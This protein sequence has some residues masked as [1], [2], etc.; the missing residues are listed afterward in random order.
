[1]KNSKNFL[2]IVMLCW[3]LVGLAQNPLIKAC[4]TGDLEAAKQA[5]ADGAD[6][7][8]LDA[9]GR[10]VLV[11]AMFWPEITQFLIEKGADPN[12]GTYPALMQAAN[13]YSYET[14][15]VLLENGA[16]VNKPQVRTR[17]HPIAMMINAERAKKKPNKKLLKTWEEQLDQQ[18]GSLEPIE[19]KL[20]T[21]ENTINQ[22]NCR[23]CLEML[24]KNGA[25]PNQKDAVG[26]DMLSNAALRH[27]P[28]GENFI[29]YGK[30][31]E[32]D[33][34]YRVPDW[35]EERVMGGNSTEEIKLLL[36]AGADLNYQ[37]PSNGNTPLLAA[38]G[39]QNSEGAKLLISKGADVTILTPTKKDALSIAASIGDVPLIKMIVERGADVNR[40]TW[41]L[42]Q[43]SGQYA[44]GFTPLTI[45]VVNDHIDAARFLIEAGSAPK[46]GVSGY[47]INPKSGCPY[48]L[49]S[50][51]AIFYAVENDNR[52]MLEMLTDNFKMWNKYDMEMNQPDNTNE[53]DFGSITVEVT[54]CWKIKGRF[55]PS[56]YAKKLGNKEVGEY[57]KSKGL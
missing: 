21:L 49:K 37:N 45:A 36:D 2:T 6:V 53:I 32:N 50:K 19:S 44:K 39:S 16:D 47:H 30:K 11:H 34:G 33:W 24:L 15:E 56:S 7:N 8:E 38:L 46:E 57:L 3:A 25:N 48:K 55:T 9:S 5:V 43:A 52:E 1:M 20:S 13:H 31:L 14:M 54:S 40:E 18:G 12:G 10:P 23:K 26:N 4:Q 17:L 42:D 41:D 22:T 27:L 51:T 29:T 28:V 35:F